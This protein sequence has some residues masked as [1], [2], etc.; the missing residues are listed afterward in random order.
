MD[1]NPYAITWEILRCITGISF[2]VIQNDWF[3]ASA[4]FN[5]APYL[6]AGYFIISIFTTYWL[7]VQQRKEDRQVQM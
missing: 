2:L 4:Y 6:I 7:S 1:R 3:G 5:P